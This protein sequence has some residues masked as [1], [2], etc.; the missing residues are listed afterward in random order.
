MIRRAS[1]TITAISLFCT[2]AFAAQPFELSLRLQNDSSAVLPAAE[3]CGL[4]PLALDGQVRD[5]LLSASQPL[6]Q[7]SESYCLRH[8]SLGPYQSQQIAVQWR[9]TSPLPDTA[10]MP[11][12]P[13]DLTQFPSTQLLQLSDSFAAYPQRERV[14]RI[15]AWMVGNIAFSGIRRGIDGAEHALQVGSGDCTEHMLLAGELLERNGVTIRRAL[16]VAIPKDQHRISAVAL[17]NWIEYFDNGSWL[18]FDSSKKLLGIPE[19]ESYLA[20]LFYQSSQQLSHNV[21]S[22]DSPKL[23]LFLQ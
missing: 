12:A 6:R 7:S 2:Q 8:G 10:W 23:K 21:F 5:W 13:Y 14:G 3:V 4:M 19:E 11:A 15:Y 18:V 20:L 17:H 9:P 22:T 1:L 16:G